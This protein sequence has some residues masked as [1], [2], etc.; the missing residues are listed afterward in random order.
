MNSNVQSAD[1]RTYVIGV[2]YVIAAIVLWSTVPVATRVL[3]RDGGV[4]S[5]ACISVVRLVTA[6]GIF[7]FLRAR[8]ARQHNLSLIPRIPFSGWLVAAAAGL[9]FNYIFYAVGLRY[10]TAG[11]TSVVSQVHAPATV[12]LASLVLGE[13]L[14]A[15]KITGMLVVMAGVL[16]VVLRGSAWHDLVASQHF[17]GNLIEILAALAWPLY[18]VGQTK[19]LQRDHSQYI[20]VPIFLL[21]SLFAM[22]A[23][24]FTGPLIVHSPT[25]VDW[26]L[27]AFL[28]IGS[29]AAAYW[30]FAAGMQR[31]ETS[32]G[33]ML[34]VLLPL[35]ALVTAHVA[36]GEEIHTGIIG[37]FGLVLGGLVL[38]MWHRA[39]S[40]LARGW[41]RRH[42]QRLRAAIP[43]AK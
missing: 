1:R 36:L 8:H 9:A 30:C 18:A 26:G 22:A 2:L 31:I 23:L 7:V 40:P 42:M 34:N 6:A 16:L 35:F 29:T 13:R 5:S 38:I 24:P 33:A 39:D 15:Q 27:M 19:L 41:I 28:G 3:V 37:G 20:L 43:T 25:R 17:I 14:T 11:A 12:L 32:Q 4:F 21:A 10:T